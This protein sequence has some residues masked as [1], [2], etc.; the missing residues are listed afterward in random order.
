MT[1]T[2]NNDVEITTIKNFFED[3]KQIYKNKGYMI[4]VKDYNDGE[5]SVVYDSGSE[6]LYDLAQ[7]I[8]IMMKPCLTSDI[9]GIYDLSKVFEDSSLDTFTSHLN[10]LMVYCWFNDSNISNTIH[11]KK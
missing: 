9:V 5:C 2:I 8:L 7:E 1:I 3:H 10:D 11:A 6:G 4:V